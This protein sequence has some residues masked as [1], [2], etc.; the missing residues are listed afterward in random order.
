MTR[1]ATKLRVATGIVVAL[2]LAACGQDPPSMLDSQGPEARTV[3]G[4]WWLMFA[5]AAAV[6]VVVSGFIVV[7]IVRGRRR[8]DP[9][10]ERAKESKEPKDD[11]FI[12]LGGIVAPVVILAVL[13]VVTITT[14]QDL[15]RARSD[16]LRIEVTAK[17]WWWDVRYPDAGVATASEIHIPVGRPVNIEL[18][19]DNVIHSFWVPQLAGKVDTIPGQRN[20][21][22]LQADEPGVYRG[23][24]AEYC[25]IQHANMSYLVI[26]E[27]P[28]EFDRWLTRRSS[29]AG[30]TPANEQ[31]ARG[32]VVF[33]RE[34]CAGCHAVK[35]TPATATV[36]PDLSDFGAR[37]TIGSLT[38]PNTRDNLS[39]WITEPEKV[40]PGNLMPPTALSPDDLAAV[41]AYLEGLE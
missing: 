28:A 17:R 23:A 26:A 19:S 20:S 16:E 38:V 25:G 2:G 11:T 9:D 33:N 29:G 3:E 18:L 40:K 7:A 39:R 12:W 5:L 41:I 13:A 14:T 35:G 4:V 8:R 1:P 36:G 24:C 21:L 22:R 31:A 10:R 32:Q 37:Q 34:A 6:Y 15:R 27:E 30:L